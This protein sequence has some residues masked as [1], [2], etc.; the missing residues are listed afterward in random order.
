MRKLNTALLMIAILLISSIG[1][2]SQSK[3]DKAEL[4]GFYKTR[5][6]FF[7]GKLTSVGDI[8][9]IK[10]ALLNTNTKITYTDKTGKLIKTTPKKLDYWGC[11]FDG[12]MYKFHGK[13]ALKIIVPGQIMYY[14]YDVQVVRRADRTVSSM[15][16]WSG[17]GK[18]Y[19]QKHDGKIMGLTTL[20]VRKMMWDDKMALE[21]LPLFT[22]LNYFTKVIET[23]T[24]YNSREH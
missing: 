14:A 21:M 13:K 5:K 8:E 12:D 1:A 6:D 24:F 18:F 10:I 22:M 11:D 9:E 20:R 3:S 17:D 2:Q 19:I 15:S 23:I 4:N 7:K 16:W